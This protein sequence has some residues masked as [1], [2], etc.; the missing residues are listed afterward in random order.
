[1]V[2]LTGSAAASSRGT[3]ARIRA[4]HKARDAKALAAIVLRLSRAHRGVLR[5]AHVA[6]R[7]RAE[8]TVS[9]I[10]DIEA[11]ARSIGD[12]WISSPA[13]LQ[14]CNV[15]ATLNLARTQHLAIRAARAMVSASLL[16]CATAALAEVA[17]G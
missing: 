5:S 16:A 12:E 11:W 17:H 7:L 13:L 9:N 6:E 8:A 10:L 1:M 3:V 14:R 15:S 2:S 4:A